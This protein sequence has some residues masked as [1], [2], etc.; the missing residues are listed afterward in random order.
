MLK[1]N[2]RSYENQEENS[3]DPP[4]TI[5]NL[6]WQ[7]DRAPLAF[8][9]L[10]C[11][12]LNYSISIACKIKYIKIKHC[13]FELNNYYLIITMLLDFMALKTS[14]IISCGFDWERIPKCHFAFL[15]VFLCTSGWFEGWLVESK[16]ALTSFNSVNK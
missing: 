1:V 8:L 3:F 2:L 4:D 9:L 12:Y 11:R 6:F 15:T 5:V 14:F 10:N 7:N 13:G 16:V